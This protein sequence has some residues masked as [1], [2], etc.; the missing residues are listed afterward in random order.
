MLKINLRDGN[1]AHHPQGQSMSYNY[2]PTY[3]QWERENVMVSD[4]VFLTDLFLHEVDKYKYS[5]RKVGLL[6]EPPDINPGIYEFVDKNYKKFDYILTFDRRLLE[7][8]R[9]F[10]FYPFGCSW[11]TDLSQ[12]KKTKLC[13]MIASNKRMTPGHEFRQEL[14]KRF[15]SRVDHYGNGF[16]RVEKKEDGLRDY[17]FSIVIENSQP[18]Y[19]FSEKLLDCF[20]C[21]TIPLYWGSN[22]APF[23][24]TDGMLIFNTVDELEDIFNRLTPD[25][26]DSLRSPMDDNFSRIQKYRVPEDWMYEHY[27]FLFRSTV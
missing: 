27:P 26:Y 2:Y 6:I 5:K 7:T 4:S 22:V 1:F 20:A 18:D 25:L 13:S 10:L 16:M 9:N 24:N 17:Y 11:V 12:P 23:F 3:F 14:I 15:S 8:G 21:R 19:Y